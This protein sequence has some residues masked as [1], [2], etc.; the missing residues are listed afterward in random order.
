MFALTLLLYLTGG[1]LNP[2]T[3]LFIVPVILAATLLNQRQTWFLVVLSIVSYCVLALMPTGHEHHMGGANSL[4]DVHR[5][6][7]LLG[8]VVTALLITVFVSRIAANLAE[9]DA[10]LFKINQQAEA[11]RQINALGMLAAGAAHDLGTPL[12][13]LSLIESEL[14]NTLAEQEDALPL[15]DMHARQ[16]D[17]AKRSL[18]DLMS[19]TGESRAEN[20]SPVILGRFFKQACERWHAA[21]SHVQ[22]TVAVE[23]ADNVQATADTLFEKAL[24]NLLDNAAKVSPQCVS[25]NI[26]YVDGAVKLMVSDKG[27]GISENV[28]NS[29]NEPAGLSLQQFGF[30]LFWVNAFAIRMQ[31]KLQFLRP[32]SGGTSVI[33]LLPLALKNDH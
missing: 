23:L 13:S 25:V 24:V 4:F 15:L 5:Y 29:L 10:Q 1:G 19:A 30:G 2:F 3:G 21:N 26:S 11:S 14:R 12:N 17:R 31:G 22:F 8:F 7:M 6:G 9:R 33:L 28:I 20:A 18:H 16:L 27:P 32:E